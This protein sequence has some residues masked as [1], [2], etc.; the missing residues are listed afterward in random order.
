MIILKKLNLKAASAENAD[1]ALYVNFKY[2]TR[3]MTVK[4]RV[5]SHSIVAGGLLVTS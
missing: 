4:L 2:E 5:Y 1:A 3:L